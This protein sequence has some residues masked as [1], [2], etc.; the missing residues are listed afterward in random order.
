M[1]YPLDPG[2]PDDYPVRVGSMLLTLVDPHR[3]YERAYNRWYERDHYYDGCLIGPY[4]FA[5]AR[6]VA[7]REL[8]DLRW[9]AASTVVA[10]PIVA[11][12]YLAIYW[13]ED[14]HHTDW[15]TWASEQVRWL[16]GNG[17]G[18]PE[19]SHVHT[20][21]FD[22]LG[23]GYRDRDPVPVALALDHRYGGLVVAW[24][25]ARDGRPATELSDLLAVEAVP[26][27]LRDSPIEIAAA[28]RP[29]PEFRTARDAPMALG[30][31]GGGEDRLCQLFFVDGDPRDALGPLR[32][33]T[34][35]VEERGW[36]DT[37]LVAPFLRTEV[38]TDRYAD[39]LW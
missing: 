31:V 12:S 25:D 29:R 14:G 15:D 32:E 3:G 39:Q 5:G 21:T 9:P 16:Y 26:A 6:W 38:G 13:I 19:R 37:R 20:A 34:A 11:G 36:A 1:S 27:L 17:R 23:V 4:N 2:G 33:Y 30:S 18:F 7:T 24:F 28:W 8:K 35:A 10:D 22:Y